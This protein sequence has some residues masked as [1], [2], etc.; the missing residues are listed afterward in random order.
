MNRL[1]KLVRDCLGATAIEYAMVA[2]LIAVAAIAGFN[3]LGTK[4]AAQYNNVN[5]KL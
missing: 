3:A 5:D 1:S 2:S 4:Q